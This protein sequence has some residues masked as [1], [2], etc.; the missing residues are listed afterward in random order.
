MLLSGFFALMRLGKLSFLDDESICNWCKVIC[1]DSVRVTS[2]QYR[3][4]LPHHKADH[5]FEGNQVIVHK[6]QFQH[7]PLSHFISYLTSR[8]RLFP[9]SS[10]L[11]IMSQGHIPTHSF[12]MCHLHLFFD[13]SVGRQSMRAGG[14]TSLAEHGIPPSIIQPLSCWSSQAFLIYIRKSPTLIQAFLYSE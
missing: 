13:K 3:F 9:F 10:P 7:D 6:D 12:F 1:W 11:W 2:E 4:K 14:A 8:N 5:L